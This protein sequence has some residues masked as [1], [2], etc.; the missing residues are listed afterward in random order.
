MYTYIHRH[1]YVYIF[2]RRSLSYIHS[3]PPT[4]THTHTHSQHTHK[5]M[6]VQIYM[7]T[8]NF[9]KKSAEQ[10]TPKYLAAAHLLRKGNP[11][12]H[13]HTHTHFHE[14]LQNMKSLCVCVYSLS[15]R[16]DWLHMRGRLAI[17]AWA[18]GYMCAGGLVA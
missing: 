17:Y 10:L 11:P 15:L 5:H 12:P 18:V 14:W 7:M 6:S 8:L 13:S 1:M 9:R 3:H 4:H 16:A 2:S